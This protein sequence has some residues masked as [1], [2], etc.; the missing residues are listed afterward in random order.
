[1]TQEEIIRKE[2]TEE[3]YA[4]LKGYAWV[5]SERVNYSTLMHDFFKDFRKYM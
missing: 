2:V 4:W 5:D 3:I 1:M